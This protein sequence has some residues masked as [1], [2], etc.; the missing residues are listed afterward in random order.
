MRW[1]ILFFFF[2][3]TIIAVPLFTKF[4]KLHDLIILLLTFLDKIIANLFFGFAKDSIL[5]YAGEY[6]YKF[7]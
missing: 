3:G 2:L 7:N 1:L 5:M 6:P 4:L